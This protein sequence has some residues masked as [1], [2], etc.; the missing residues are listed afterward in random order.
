MDK[1]TY[2]YRRWGVLAVTLA[3]AGLLAAA[4]GG[5]GSPTPTVQT[6]YQKVLAYS[7]CMRGHGVASFPD[8]QP[9]G[10]IL[11]SPQDH[12]TQGSPSSWQPTKRANT[13]CLLT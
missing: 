13:C 5:G 12:L 7:Q 1:V 10:A 11:A 6:A 9:N 4:C 2:G 3:G 8:P